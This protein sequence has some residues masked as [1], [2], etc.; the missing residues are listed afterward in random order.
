MVLQ[1]TATKGDDVRLPVFAAGF[2]H[3]PLDPPARDSPGETQ[4]GV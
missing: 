1:R 4:L 2:C 3:G